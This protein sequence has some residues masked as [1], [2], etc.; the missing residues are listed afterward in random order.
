MIKIDTIEIRQ[1]KINQRTLIKDR[2]EI[3]N[4][5]H[6]ID[7]KFVWSSGRKT[8][9]Y[10][11]KSKTIVIGPNAW[12]GSMPTMLHLFS[13]AICDDRCLD[14]RNH[15]HKFC[16]TLWKLVVSHY[17]GIPERYPW[18][19]EHNRVREFGRLHCMDWRASKDF[20]VN[21]RSS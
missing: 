13:H 16:E 18:Y 14:Y 15:T 9:I 7:T 10:L 8:G 6:N 21:I 1:R 12:N 11:K 20:P 4:R 17:D 19:G 3:L 5:V 2:I